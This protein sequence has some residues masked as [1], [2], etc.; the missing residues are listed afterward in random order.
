MLGLENSRGPKCLLTAPPRGSRVSCC[1][2]TTLDCTSDNTTSVLPL[3]R[4]H[5]FSQYV[6][7]SASHQGVN[8]KISADR[9]DARRGIR[10]VHRCTRH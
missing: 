6:V 9:S 8:S 7:P 2:W 5:I 4:L 10:Q 1:T 3:Y